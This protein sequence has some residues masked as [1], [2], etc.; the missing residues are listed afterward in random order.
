MTK[1]LKGGYTTGACVAAGVKAAILFSQGS[2]CDFVDITALDGTK[3]TIPIKDIENAGEGIKVSV[4]KDGGDD[5]DITNGAVVIT[6]VEFD[7][8]ID[9]LE[10]TA[11]E[12]VG[13]VTKAGLAVSPG[14]PAINPGPR[15]LIK[16]TVEAAYGKVIGCRIRIDIPG[17]KELAKKTLNPILGIR[18]GISILGTTGVLKPMSEEAF[19]DSLVPQIKVAYAAGYTSQI[20]V[21]GKIGERIAGEWGLP[22]EAMVQTSNFIGHMLEKAAES[23]VDKVL[24]F[25]HIGKL[26]KV[27]AGVFHTHNRVGDGRLETMAAYSAAAGMPAEGVREILESLTTEAALPVIEK[28]GLEAVYETIAARA[29]QRAQRLVFDE[30]TVGT[31]LVTLKGSL[32]GMDDN[33]RMI[34]GEL[35]W[36][37]KS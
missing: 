9:Y 32:L 23:G 3:L 15:Q 12:G 6:T 17:G 13:T 30:L 5:P 22:V 31:V 21:P 14:E 37:I 8:S 11:G 4:I 34:G 25:G 19:K 2:C 24:L 7:E 36:H 10:F 16:E 18:D 29:S 26:A 27:A 1:E 35:G 28:Y 33:A 20:F